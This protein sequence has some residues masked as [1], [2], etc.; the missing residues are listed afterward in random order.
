MKKFMLGFFKKYKCFLKSMIN[1]VSTSGH[2]YE[3]E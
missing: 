1:R 3:C 2:D